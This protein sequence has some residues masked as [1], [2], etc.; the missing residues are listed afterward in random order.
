M[1]DS[2]FSQCRQALDNLDFLRRQ[3][4][5]TLS[6]LRELDDRMAITEGEIE[7]ARSELQRIL[8][9]IESIGQSAISCAVGDKRDC[10]TLLVGLAN[11][12]HAFEAKI[13]R[14]GD[15]LR[16]LSVE[17]DGVQS[18][19]MGLDADISRTEVF[20]SDHRCW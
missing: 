3:K 15:K 11:E 5:E 10:L 6:R 8:D 13:G 19:V 9:K 2:N 7:A 12:Q 16:S 17:R 20:L 18:R 1:A 14:L 4:Q